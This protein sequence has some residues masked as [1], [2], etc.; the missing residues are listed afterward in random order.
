[1]NSLWNKKLKN[2]N[3]N[4]FIEL[5]DDYISDRVNIMLDFFIDAGYYYCK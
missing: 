2:F 4:N 1:M 3:C 5:T